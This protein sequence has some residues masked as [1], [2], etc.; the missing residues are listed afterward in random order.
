MAVGLPAWQPTDGKVDGADRDCDDNQ[1]DGTNDKNDMA[2]VRLKLDPALSITDGHVYL[3][4]TGS[5]Q[6]RVFDQSDA[7]FL[8]PGQT[9][10]EIPFAGING[11]TLTFHAEGVVPGEVTLQLTF[12]KQD[13]PVLVESDKAVL[14]V[15][16]ADIDVDS[17]NSGSITAA[18]D[19]VEED[20]VGKAIPVNDDKDGG[21]PNLDCDDAVINGQADRADMAQI[22][23]RLDP[24]LNI[25]DG[26]V[27][28]RLSAAGRLRAGK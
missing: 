3:K 18:D 20:L 13:P 8:A 26:H 28:L 7:E 15:V 22:Q 17:D 25:A 23:L 2:E 9:Q 21:G 27:F 4:V 1:V 11:T 5:G 6:V 10:R 19:P 12:V 14:T 24:A 16:Q